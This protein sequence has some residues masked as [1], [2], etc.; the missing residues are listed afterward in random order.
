VTS[1]DD[2]ADGDHDPTP[3]RI[4]IEPATS[5]DRLDVLRVLD[6]AMLETDAAALDAR[7]EARDVLVARFDR[8]GSVIGALVLTRPEP[9]RRHVDAVAVRRARRGRGIGSALVARAVREARGDPSVNALTA[10]FDADL[11][12]FYADLGFS[13]EST[14]DGRARGRW[15]VGSAESDGG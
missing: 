6:A 15:S 13:I 8:T 4:T 14:G 11:R 3:E 7:I 1:P 5:S 10:A 9:G 12:G 2:R